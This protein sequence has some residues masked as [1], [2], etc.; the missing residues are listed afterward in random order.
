MKWNDLTMKERSDLMS[1][2]LKNGIGSLSDMRRIYDGEHDTGLQKMTPQEQAEAQIRV[3]NGISG[4][5]LNPGTWAGGLRMLLYK[6]KEKP[7]GQSVKDFTLGSGFYY[8][9]STAD[10]ETAEKYRNDIVDAFFGRGIPFEEAGVI[11]KRVS[12]DEHIL[13][14]RVAEHRARGKR[15]PTYQTHR[16]TLDRRLVEHLDSLLNAGLVDIRNRRY[17][18]GTPPIFTIGNT[19]IRYDGK[20]IQQV[21]VFDEKTGKV[22]RKGIDLYDF[23]PDDWTTMLVPG[24]RRT[25]QNFDNQGEPFIMSTPWE[26]MW[27]DF[28][29]K[30][31]KKWLKKQK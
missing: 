31:Y 17:N 7:A 23:N 21:S 28:T 25:L 4:A 27:Y 14:T 13:R 22:Y 30:T 9:G 6:G 2:F 3:S 8:N 24:A 20:N 16:D 19:G 29:P 18:T 11:E 5:P 15:V 26:E 10:K 12:P 1:L